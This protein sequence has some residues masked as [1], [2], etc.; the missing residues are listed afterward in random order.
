MKKLQKWLY[1]KGRRLWYCKWFE[2]R[3][4]NLH[5]RDVVGLKYRWLA[6]VLIFITGEPFFDWKET[7]D[8]IERAIK[9]C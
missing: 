2:K 3:A 8:I 9:Q 5:G 4:V 6:R 1:Q 7:K